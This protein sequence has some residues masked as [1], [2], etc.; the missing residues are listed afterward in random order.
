MGSKRSSGLT[1][2]LF[3]RQG[4]FRLRYPPSSSG[5]S[6]LPLILMR[7]RKGCTDCTLFGPCPATCC[8]WSIFGV[9]PGS[10]LCAS[11]A[12][13]EADHSLRRD[14]PDGLARLSPLHTPHLGLRGRCQYM[15][16][17]HVVWQPL[18]LCLRGSQCH[19]SARRLIGVRLTRLSSFTLGMW[20]LSLSHTLCLAQQ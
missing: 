12:L 3:P 11:V 2:P 5:S 19:T 20:P 10:S 9:Q 18:W 4:A 13:R 14:C 17:P 6:N 16:T 7:R 15:L 8:A 1:L